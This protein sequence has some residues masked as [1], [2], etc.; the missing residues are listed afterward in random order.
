MGT[1]GAKTVGA[2]PL[3][4]GNLSNSKAVL[5]GW[6]WSLTVQGPTSGFQVIWNSSGM[7]AGPTLGL[8]PGISV[9]RTWS[10]CS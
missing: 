10:G 6:S 2:G 9:S 8:L 5:S 4:F 1:P 7:L 3:L